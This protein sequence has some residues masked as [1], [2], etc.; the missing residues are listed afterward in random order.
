MARRLFDNLLES[1][2]AGQ[3]KKKRAIS[4]PVSIG[5]HV[6]VLSAV[7]LIP[8]L[9]SSRDLPEPALGAVSAFFVEPAPPPPPP[10]PP[11]PAAA[12]PKEATAPKVEQPKPVVQEEPKFTAPV[13]TP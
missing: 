1:G 10:P 9:M 2:I 13:E 12:K 7:V 11:P 4:L 5:I 8:I 3:R 6:A